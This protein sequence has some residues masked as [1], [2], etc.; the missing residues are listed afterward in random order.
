MSVTRFTAPGAVPI[1]FPARPS[2]VPGV[3]GAVSTP[4]YVTVTVTNLT[5]EV[6]RVRIEFGETARG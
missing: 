4:V 6:N 3:S 1:P 5:S 2:V